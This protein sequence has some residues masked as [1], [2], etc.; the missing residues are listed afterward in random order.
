MPYLLKKYLEKVVSEKAL[1]PPPTF[2]VLHI[3]RA[4]ELIAEK[5][6]GRG[7]LAEN[8]NVG[9]GAIRT[10]ISRLKDAGLITTSKTGCT[11]TDK[12]LKLFKE[13][14]SFFKKKI[15]IG[16]NELTIAKHSFAV[17]IKNCGHKIKSGVEQ[18]DAAIMAGAKGATTLLFK[19]GCLIIPA[20]S[21]DVAKD[22]PEAASQIMASMN[23]EEDDVI[24]VS[25][26]DSLEKAEYGALAAAWKLLDDC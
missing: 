26:A 25:S 11:L 8:L 9:E 5:P 18:R 13:Y 1:G 14:Q 4:L 3:L 20:V 21:D 10:I 7:K 23:P 24:I 22:F 2:S 16:K 17:L 15:E 12:G 19:K 6:T